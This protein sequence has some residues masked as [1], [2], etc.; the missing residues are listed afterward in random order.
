VSDLVFSEA[1]KVPDY[2]K[3]Q[4]SA[5]TAYSNMDVDDFKQVCDITLWE[6]LNEFDA[7]RSKFTTFLYSKTKYNLKASSQKPLPLVTEKI[8]IPQDHS[9][10][11]DLRN[12]IEDMPEPHRNVIKARFLEEKSVAQI[13]SMTGKSASTIHRTIRQGIKYLR[14]RLGV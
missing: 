6:C 1:S 7:S 3:I 10:I 8:E 9:L 13:I 4:S 12:I 2:S 5:G 14:A 11:I